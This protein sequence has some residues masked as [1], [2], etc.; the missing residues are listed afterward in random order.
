MDQSHDLRL[1]HPSRIIV[2]GP[3][4][5]G[6]STLVMKILANM[7]ILF[8]FKFDNIYYVSGQAFPDEEYINGVRI[9]KYNEISKD[10]IN[11][12][13]ETEK[14]VIV[15][16]DNI[17]VTNDKLLSDLFTKLSHHK[18]ITVFL[19]LQ[20]LFPKTKFSRDISINSNYIILLSN[21]RETIQV[22][23]L[24]QQVYGDNFLYECYKDAT[25]DK[26][27]SYLLI[28]FNQETPD[29]LRIRNGIFPNEMIYS[30]VKEDK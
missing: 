18:N 11:E 24:S 9:E 25:K 10:L 19:L 14:N 2:F 22:K 21:P 6:K 20:N 1:K 23:K 7:R 3:S 4:S 12:I 15:L 13:D 26:P 29:F 17:Y 27:Y 8:G 28:D 5:S 30:Y 16:D